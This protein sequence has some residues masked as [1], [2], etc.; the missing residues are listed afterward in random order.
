[1]THATTLYPHVEQMFRCN[2]RMQTVR[3]LLQK[4]PLLAHENTYAEGLCKKQDIECVPVHQGVYWEDWEVGT[5][6]NKV[7]IS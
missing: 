3:E 2:Q 6:P 1:M 7:K 5:L 4:Q